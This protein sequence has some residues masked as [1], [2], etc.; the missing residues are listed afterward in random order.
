[1]LSKLPKWVELGGF[2]LAFNAGSINAVGLLGFKHESVSHL[3]GAST[4]L[5]KAAVHSDFAHAGHLAL[6]ILCFMLG[7][8][9][10]SLIVGNESLRMGRHYGVALFVEALLLVG[11]TLLLKDGSSHGHLLASAACGLQNA[12]ATTYSGAIVRT[13][14]VTGLVTDLGIAIGGAMR[15]EPLVRRKIQLLSALIIGFV[16]GSGTGAYLFQFYD[17]NTLLM[18]AG[19]CFLLSISYRILRFLSPL[20]PWEEHPD[21]IG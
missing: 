2:L 11:A 7:A 5:A 21:K 14:H 16:L 8:T 6:I 4:L 17:Y 15:G 20:M 1:M 3:S 9:L 19:L 12:M 10:S 18:S 13:T